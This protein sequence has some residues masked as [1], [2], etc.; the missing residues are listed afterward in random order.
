MR[1]LH[2]KS[3]S[4]GYA[5]GI[6]FVYNKNSSFKVNHRSIEQEQVHGEFQRF[7]DALQKSSRELNNLRQK[8]LSE[9]GHSESQIFAAHLSF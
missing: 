6:A 7:H 9:L 3:V 4:P 5:K 1:V 2:G 8:V